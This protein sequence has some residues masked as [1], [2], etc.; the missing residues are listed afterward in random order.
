MNNE[1]NKNSARLKAAIDEFSPSEEQKERIKA[2][3]DAMN[4]EQ[5]AKKKPVIRSMR[6]VYAA[7]ACAA[8][9]LCAV[10]LTTLFSGHA[11]EVR[12]FAESAYDGK[13]E[14]QVDGN[15]ESYSYS[16]VPQAT[17]APSPESALES[18]WASDSGYSDEEYNGAAPFLPLDDYYSAA[19]KLNFFGKIQP[20]ERVQITIP[21]PSPDDFA[22][23]Q[24]IM[25]ELC[26]DDRFVYI[27]MRYAADNTILTFA[28]GT[29]LTVRNAVEQG[30]ISGEELVLNDVTSVLVS[31]LRQ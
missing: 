6:F 5:P 18:A 9:V 20:Q 21:A 19:Q 29:Q 27:I 13:P 1:N 14:Y 15:A 26:R 3:L 23:D 16:S 2:R 17:P 11:K 12:D 8:C 28:D 10:A 24:L 4:S 25:Q 31:E 7:A 30:L 22:G